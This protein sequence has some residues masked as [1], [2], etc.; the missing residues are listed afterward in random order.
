M[1][2][3][4]VQILVLVNK[5]KTE[6][7]NLYSVETEWMLL[8]RKVRHG[9]NTFDHGWCFVDFW[10]DVLQVWV[11]VSAVSMMLVLWFSAHQN[12]PRDVSVSFTD[13][14]DL[15]MFSNR[16]NVENAFKT[17]R[18]WREDGHWCL[19]STVM[20]CVSKLKCTFSK[21]R[22]HWFDWQT[23]GFTVRDVCLMASSKIYYNLLFRT[24]VITH[25]SQK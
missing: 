23:N 6:D 10:F 16:N 1:K 11:S 14:I 8:R 12:R 4:L 15:W 17:K 20:R 25:L 3:V 21:K 13:D 9:S 19:F 2:K 7:K 18:E 5:T 24:W 22:K